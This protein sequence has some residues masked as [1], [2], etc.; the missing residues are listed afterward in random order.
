MFGI[1]SA[2][3]TSR[4]MCIPM[5]KTASP[6]GWVVCGVRAAR[7]SARERWAVR[8]GRR[9]GRMLV[10]ISRGRAARAR[11][12]LG[13]LALQVAGSAAG[14]SAGRRTRWV[15]GPGPPAAGSA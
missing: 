6:A 9:P 4:N 8:T 11:P 1:L 5:R 3:M 12:G 14:S 15:P 10:A 13:S 2:G 7:V